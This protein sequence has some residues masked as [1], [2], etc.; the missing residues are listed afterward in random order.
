M[1]HAF[2]FGPDKLTFLSLDEKPNRF[3]ACGGDKVWAIRG[4]KAVKCK[5]LRAM[6]L[7][8]W[9]SITAVF[10]RRHPAA[11]LPNGEWRPKWAALF[12]AVE[13]SR[14]DLTSPDDRR[15]QILF[16]P[17]SYTHLTLPTKA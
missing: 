17:V 13:G 7:D 12:R 11:L 9:T 1:L 4:Q 3:N 16:A 5:E 8:R 10:S 2:L 15:A 6:L 14:I